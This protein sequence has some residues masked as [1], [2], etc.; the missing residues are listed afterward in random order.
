M[1][2]VAAR[3]LYLPKY[4]PIYNCSF[5][6]YFLMTVIATKESVTGG[7]PFEVIKQIFSHLNRDELKECQ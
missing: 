6:T 3:K 5:F 7:L 1:S 2:R 4:L